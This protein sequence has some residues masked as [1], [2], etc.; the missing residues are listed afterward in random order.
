MKVTPSRL[1]VSRRAQASL[2]T[3]AVTTLFLAFNTLSPVGH[4]SGFYTSPPPTHR[5]LAIS[6]H[7]STYVKYYETALSSSTGGRRR[8]FTSLTDPPGATAAQRILLLTIADDLDTFGESTLRD[9][10]RGGYNR[11]WTFNDY[12]ARVRA[13]GMPASQMSLGLLTGSLVAFENYTSTL[14]ALPRAMPW[15]SAEILYLP[16]LPLVPGGDNDAGNG[17]RTRQYMAR[18]RN[19][20][21]ASTLSDR[22]AHL[23]WL[24]ADVVDLPRGLFARFVEV[25]GLSDRQDIKSLVVASVRVDDG[26]DSDETGEAGAPMEPEMPLSDPDGDESGQGQHDGTVKETQVAR[27]VGLL[28][29]RLQNA[30]GRDVDRG[31]WRGYGRR[32]TAWELSQILDKGHSFKGQKDWA[33]ALAQLL[34]GTRDEELIQLDAVGGSVLYMR[35]ELVREGLVFPVYRIREGDHEEGNGGETEGLCYVAGRMGWGCYGLGG[36][37]HALHADF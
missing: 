12:I 22:Y 34:P 20:L 24:D 19:Y 7:S 26:S 9:A 23:V 30:S 25:A 2:V 1:L 31:S 14:L 32:P 15:S 10:R 27:P 18:L 13:Q 16:S 17:R 3:L 4:P 6:A 8:S 21:M 35:A 33:K 5:P 36:S 37:W 11:T 29:L 28:T